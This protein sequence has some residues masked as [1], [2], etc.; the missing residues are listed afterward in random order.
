MIFVSL[1][2]MDMPFVRMAKAVDELAASLEEE[3]IVQTG[4]TDYPYQHVT[5]VFPFC[6]KDEMQEYISQASILILQGGWGAIS[7]AM[8]K[9]K[10]IVVIPRKDKT[11]HIH[12]QFQLIRKLDSIGCVIGVFDER[13]LPN[14][15]EKAR[16]FHFCKIERGNAEKMIR[17]KLEKWFL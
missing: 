3:V 2:T 9:S 13:L 10:R 1:G 15:V 6:T 16:N 12:D 7:E 8:E 11:E 17:E 4:Y 5:K 14:A